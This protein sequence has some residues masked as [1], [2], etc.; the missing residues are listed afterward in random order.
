MNSVCG[1]AIRMRPPRQ[2]G[3]RLNNFPRGLL[4]AS[5]GRANGYAFPIGGAHRCLGVIS[6][7]AKRGCS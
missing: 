5:A 2:S 4:A 3:R 6:P 7:I 1:A